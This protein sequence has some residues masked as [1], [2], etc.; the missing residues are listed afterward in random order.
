MT[1]FGG[2]TLAVDSHFSWI[3]LVTCPRKS[4]NNGSDSV[5]S[6]VNR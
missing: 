5:L 1:L 4:S 2:S 6:L 3:S